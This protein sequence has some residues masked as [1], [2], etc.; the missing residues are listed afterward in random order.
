MFDRTLLEEA[1]DITS[2]DRMESYGHPLINFLREALLFSILEG[3]VV[4]PL[5]V[6]RQYYVKKLCREYNRFKWDNHVDMAGYAATMD[7]LNRA[8]MELGYPSGV[9][10][11]ERMG[12]WVPAIHFMTS[13]LEMARDRYEPAK[14]GGVDPYIPSDAEA[15]IKGVTLE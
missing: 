4:S 10:N 8:M 6:V 7:N 11:F 9:K 5:D 12:G 1:A 15:I 14:G 2:G 3:R 13:L